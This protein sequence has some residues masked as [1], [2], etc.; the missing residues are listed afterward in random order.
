MVIAVLISC[1][2]SL[3]GSDIST[4]SQECGTISANLDGKVIPRQQYGPP[5]WGET[6]Q[7]DTKWT[8]YVLV[9]SPKSVKTVA[10]IFAR[11]APEHLPLREVQLWAN[12][13][14][15]AGLAKYNFRSVYISG[16]L[17]LAQGAPA[18]LLPVQMRITNIVEP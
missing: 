14:E 2:C 7:R 4:L 17:S 10:S 8:M 18:E 12:Q 16:V 15:G 3:V 6:P 11:C 13:S 1:G 9:L 5:G